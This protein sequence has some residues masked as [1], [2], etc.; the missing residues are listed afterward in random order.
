MR[1]YGAACMQKASLV[2][3]NGLN[4]TFCCRL[5]WGYSYRLILIKAQYARSTNTLPG[6][7]VEH[8]S[9]V[10]LVVSMLPQDKWKGSITPTQQANISML[11]TIHWKIAVTIKNNLK[12]VMVI[13]NVIPTSPC[14]SAHSLWRDLSSVAILYEARR[15]KWHTGVA[16]SA[17][18]DPQTSNQLAHTGH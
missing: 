15:A 8:S 10:W 17:A 9:P 1:N 14:I 6:R 12:L 18:H 16:H 3:I 7:V 13:W 2:L 11:N 5:P 4:Q